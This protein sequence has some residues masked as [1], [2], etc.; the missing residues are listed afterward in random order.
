M[1]QYLLI[2]LLIF[3]SGREILQP[4]LMRRTHYFLIANNSCHQFCP[5]ITNS[6]WQGLSMDKARYAGVA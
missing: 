6:E 4:I 5:D 1:D 2:W 3:L